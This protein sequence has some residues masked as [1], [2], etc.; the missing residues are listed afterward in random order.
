MR[1]V[2]DREEALPSVP[3]CEDLVPRTFSQ[4]YNIFSKD[5][6]DGARRLPYILPRKETSESAEWLG[7][8]ARQMHR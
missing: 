1:D 7:V 8:L 4:D 6:T 3:L 5:L 2:S